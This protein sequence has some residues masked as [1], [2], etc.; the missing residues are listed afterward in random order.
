M[1]EFID[2]CILCG[3]DYTNTIRGVGPT[4]ALNYIQKYKTI[5]KVIEVIEEENLSNT[6][7]TKYIIPDTFEYEKSRDL[8]INPDIIEVKS[9]DVSPS[10]LNLQL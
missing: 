7:K 5:E 6:K 1:Q 10:H 3:C 4:R 2:M 9:T 8:F